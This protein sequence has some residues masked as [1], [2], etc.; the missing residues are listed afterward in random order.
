MTTQSITLL[1]PQMTAPENRWPPMSAMQT[2]L[3]RGY[4]ESADENFS[5]SLCAH[6]GLHA[7]EGE[8]LPLAALSAMGDGLSAGDGWWLHADPVHLVADRDQLFL[9]A[10]RALQLTQLEADEMVAEL[11]RIYNDDGWHFVAA[12]P[13]RWYLRLPH[14]M[15]IRLIPTED[16]MGRR[17][18]EVLPQGDDALNWQR[19]M[20][21][22]QMLLHT[23]QVN[24]TRNA[25]GTLAVNGVWFWGGGIL[26]QAEGAVAW[27]S[28][29]ADHPLA[30]GL[31]QLYGVQVESTGSAALNALEGRVLW[32]GDE[33][34]AEKLEQDYFAPLLTWLQ[35]GELGEL[36]IELPGIARWR[37]NRKALRRW[38]RRRKPISS[39]L[40]GD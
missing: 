12:A 33:D 28:V 11:N 6:F 3:S 16:A 19:V 21:E 8:E 24:V 2:L 27:H 35:A 1:L 32:V 5:T 30:R 10:S 26:P 31:A 38:W 18:G 17:V 7:G 37:I 34:T 4:R 25:K 29:V 9:S 40:K 13:Q 15:A 14:P 36:V 20:T 23:S 22:V 39:L